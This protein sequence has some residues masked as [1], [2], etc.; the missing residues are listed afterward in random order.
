MP[1]MFRQRIVVAAP[2]VARSKKRKA[3]PNTVPEEFKERRMMV[4][5]IPVPEISEGNSEQ[6][7]SVFDDAGSASNGGSVPLESAT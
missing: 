4:R 6:D 3:P 5:A 1:S 7:W 2:P